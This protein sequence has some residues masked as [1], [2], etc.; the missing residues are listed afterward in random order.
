MRRFE[1]ALRINSGNYYLTKYSKNV[2][3]TNNNLV[4]A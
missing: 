3:K 2:I 1:S 4:A